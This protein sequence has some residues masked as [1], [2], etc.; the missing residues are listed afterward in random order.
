[1]TDDRGFPPDAQSLRPQS[2]KRQTNRAYAKR[3]PSALTPDRQREAVRAVRA[4][5]SVHQVAAE[6][7]VSESVIQ[8]LWA[9]DVERKTRE[10]LDSLRS[11]IQEIDDE[12]RGRKP[13]AQRRVA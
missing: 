6:F 11:Q 9:R 5:R 2:V 8:E 13:C 10:I 7:S 1:M 12:L 4:G 3:V